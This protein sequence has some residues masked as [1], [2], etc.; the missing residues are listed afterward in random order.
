VSV[1]DLAV[2][3]G[4]RFPRLGRPR[5]SFDEFPERHMEQYLPLRIGNFER[6]VQRIAAGCEKLWPHRAGRSDGLQVSLLR[7]GELEPDIVARPAFA[8]VEVEEEL[9]HDFFRLPRRR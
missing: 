2:Q 4:T 9:R 8:V 1:L 6:A 3:L 7:A 5:A